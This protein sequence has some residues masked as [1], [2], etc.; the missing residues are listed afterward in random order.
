MPFGQ[1]PEAVGLKDQQ[2][3]DAFRR[4]A[5]GDHAAGPLDQSIHLA[6][7]ILFHKMYRFGDLALNAMF[8]FSVPVFVIISGYLL[9]SRPFSNVCG[10]VLL[11][12]VKMVLCSGAY[13]LYSLWEGNG[14]P[15]QPIIY[16]LTAPIHLWYLYATMGLYLLTPA[17]LPFVRSADEKEYRYT[18]SVCFV[19]G[20]CVVTLVR[21]NWFPLLALVLDKSKLP[22]MLGFTGLY[23]LGGYF[24]RF[25]FG[26]R[27]IW[28]C[29]W[30]VCSVLS[31]AASRT[32]FAE[33]L[34]SF[35]SP[36]VVLS[37]CACFAVVM[38]LPEPAARFRRPLSS[39]AACTMGVY[40]FHMM[41]SD[42][43]TPMITL[44]R[45]ILG[46][47]AAMT[48]RGI[49]VFSVTMTAVWLLRKSPLLKKW[50]L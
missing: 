45:R 8:R 47:A 18:L 40:L 32:P 35:L 34:L 39:A 37:G 15:E 7:E 16:L 44:S 22:D 48:L 26:R 17:L 13:L 21:L 12:A 29:I 3:A 28:L 25:G 41:V 24:R 6:V 23:L 4:L 49:L 38:L 10:K 36:T 43:L 50:M 20:S 19:L 33:Y 1:A 5:E 14:M 42:R 9:L 46:G 30:T 2:I 27:S 31:I 11:L